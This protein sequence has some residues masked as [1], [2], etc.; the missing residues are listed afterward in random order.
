MAALK[1]PE[2]GQEVATMVNE[3]A[4]WADPAGRDN[5]ERGAHFS[6]WV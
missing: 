3:A 2:A 4:N 5:R 1:A 6:R